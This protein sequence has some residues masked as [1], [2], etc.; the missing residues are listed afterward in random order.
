MSVLLVGYDLNSP[1][2]NYVDLIESIEEYTCCHALD[3]MWFVDTQ[4]APKEVHK[5]LS[6][7]LDKGDQL[8]VMRLH[9]HWAALRA[10]N[11]ETFDR[12]KF[13]LEG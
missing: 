3:S 9:K 12:L 2:Q 1:G 5:D 8:Y 7:H 6:A 11:S 10:N 4:K 13:T